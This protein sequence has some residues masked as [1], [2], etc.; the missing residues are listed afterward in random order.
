MLMKNVG[1]WMDKEKAIVVNLIDGHESLET[2]ESNVETYRIHGGHGTR[3]KG[4]PQDVVQDSKYLERQ[5]HQLKAYFKMLLP[6]LRNADQFVLFGPAET[7]QKFGKEIGEQHAS[8]SKKMSGIEKA[9]S[10]TQNQVKAW[11][12][13]YFG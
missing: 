2:I 4:G 1:I 10:M 6:Y 12:R 9:D 8:L 13:E 5:K 3:I 7:A 11:V